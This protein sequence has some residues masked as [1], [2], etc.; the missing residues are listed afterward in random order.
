MPDE[1]C[2]GFFLTE[3]AGNP[4]PS[5]P[6][7]YAIDGDNVDEMD[8]HC[9]AAA[10]EELELHEE[11][12]VR[13]HQQGDREGLRAAIEG[14]KDA[15]EKGRRALEEWLASV[16]ESGIALGGGEY[17]AMLAQAESEMRAQ[18]D[19][20]FAC[21]SNGGIGAVRRILQRAEES[22]DQPLCEAVHEVERLDL[23]LDLVIE[24]GH[25]GE[26]KG[27]SATALDAQDRGPP[28][29]LP[30][31]LSDKIEARV[32]SLLARPVESE[33]GMFA[34]AETAERL[35]HIG[36]ALSRMQ[37][38]GQLEK[39]LVSPDGGVGAHALRTDPIT[40]VDIRVA[41]VRDA[42]AVQEG[43]LRIH[44]LAPDAPPSDE[45][46]ERLRR[47]LA[48]VHGLAACQKSK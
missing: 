31:L 12:R 43:L 1:G 14:Q 36:A 20:L 17:S 41:A 46:A 38:S 15:A 40:E 9:L 26:A 33:G 11:V 5:I 3:P 10:V 19:A 16:S 27:G 21:D 37:Q 28:T 34:G 47:L 2:S 24:R 32:Q 42:S 4:E 35:R 45:E 8:A 22:G 7:E 6:G 13:Q 48:H 30:Q 44:A 39:R 29:P 25:G 23:E 18:R